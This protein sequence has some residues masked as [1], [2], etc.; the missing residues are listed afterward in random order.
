MVS[1]IYV[2]L[3]GRLLQTPTSSIKKKGR[4]AKRVK[5]QAI[6]SKG[7]RTRAQVDSSSE[8]EEDEEGERAPELVLVTKVCCS[9]RYYC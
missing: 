5:R 9:C 4:Q 6:T 2:A 8:G 7:K 1:V 3:T